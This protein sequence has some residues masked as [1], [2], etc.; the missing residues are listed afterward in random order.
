MVENAI[1]EIEAGALINRQD[2][3]GT[4][5]RF[6]RIRP[7]VRYVESRAVLGRSERCC[8]LA[9]GHWYRRND[10][11]TLLDGKTVDC[12][13]GAGGRWT[14]GV[15][16]NDDPISARRKRR[17]SGADGDIQWRIRRSCGRSEVHDVR[18]RRRTESDET[19][20]FRRSIE[21]DDI[22]SGRCSRGRDRIGDTPE[23]RDSTWTSADSIQVDLSEI[24]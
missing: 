5:I 10:G 1:E 2:R 19:Q 15:S 11:Q 6:R 14:C 20:F 4:A 8:V 22:V 12:L 21:S 13:Y 7:E 17:A 9:D 16:E 24:L 23:Q 3:D 18:R